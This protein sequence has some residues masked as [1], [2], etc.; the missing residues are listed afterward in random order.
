MT[1]GTNCR[2]QCVPR[3][4]VGVLVLGRAEA[5]HHQAESLGTQGTVYERRDGTW[6]SCPSL[7]RT[8]IGNIR[9]CREWVRYSWNI[10]GA[11]TSCKHFWGG[12][13]REILEFSLCMIQR[14]GWLSCAFSMRLRSIA[15]RK[16]SLFEAQAAQNLSP[17]SIKRSFPVRKTTELHSTLNLLN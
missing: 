3:D 2:I 17:P 9:K 15:G 13:K 12:M 8:F 10:A 6:T 7:R 5:A 14:L 16:K 11:D 1:A 4:V